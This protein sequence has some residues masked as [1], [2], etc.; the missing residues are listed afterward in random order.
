MK[1]IKSSIEQTF[2]GKQA[3]SEFDLN[4]NFILEVKTFKTYDGDVITYAVIWFKKSQNHRTTAFDFR[5]KNINHGKL[6]LTQNKLIKFHNEAINDNFLN[7]S[8]IDEE[9]NKFNI[10]DII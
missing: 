7:K 6:R 4:N 10:S 2:H 3:I 9:I 8:F 5:S 1:L